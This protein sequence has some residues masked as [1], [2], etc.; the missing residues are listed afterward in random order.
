MS[1]QAC[2]TALLHQLNRFDKTTKNLLLS[3]SSQVSQA[4]RIISA[5]EPQVVGT[6]IFNYIDP[7]RLKAAHTISN[8]SKSR[9]DLYP[10]KILR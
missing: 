10:S 5:A 3:Q 1:S 4:S 2:S 8:M 9:E 7:S 6:G